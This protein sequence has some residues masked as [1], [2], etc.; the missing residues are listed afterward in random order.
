M[1]KRKTVLTFACAFR[2]SPSQIEIVKHLVEFEKV[3][4][5]LQNAR[6]GNTAL[7]TASDNK[8]FEIVKY[9]VEQGADV[10]LTNQGGNSALAIA[11]SGG[12][13]NIAKYLI[14]L[15]PTS[16]LNL[17]N[18]RGN[19]PLIDCCH[20][21]RF[22]LIK[23]L[24]EKGA[25]FRISNSIGQTPVEICIRFGYFEIAKYFV[26]EKGADFPYALLSDVKLQTLY[27]NLDFF[28]EIISPQKN[29]VSK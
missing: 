16:S 27:G 4:L 14:D 28:L 11:C 12:Y 13:V 10:S 26:V 18:N 22:Q 15:V 1:K 21:G 25:D 9:L 23:Y 17:K 5:N 24:V 8:N 7:C 2:E 19:T 3:N 6:D 20:F 29:N